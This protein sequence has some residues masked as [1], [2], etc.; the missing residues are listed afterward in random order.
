MK[1]IRKHRS[2]DESMDKEFERIAKSKKGEAVIFIVFA[3]A[4]GV[5]VAGQIR[6]MQETKLPK[7][8]IDVIQSVANSGSYAR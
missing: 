7:K 3:F 5:W 2:I 1:R 6:L 4:I 8:T